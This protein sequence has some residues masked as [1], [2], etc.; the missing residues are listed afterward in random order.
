MIGNTSFARERQESV[1][2]TGGAEY[3]VNSRPQEVH[4][5]TDGTERMF[6]TGEAERAGVGYMRRPVLSTP[7]CYMKTA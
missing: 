1:S 7:P 4:E 5:R 2:I 3:V 6:G